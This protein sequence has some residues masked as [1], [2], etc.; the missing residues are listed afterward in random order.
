MS[1]ETYCKPSL[2]AESFQRLLAAAFILQSRLDWISRNPIR[3]ADAKRFAAL[4][5]A[6]KRT[7]SIRTSLM[8]WKGVEAVAIAII[9]CLM[10]GMSI[11]HL[12]GY[13]SST[14]SSGKLQ[15]R[16]AGRL[17]RSAPQVLLSSVLA[18]SQ[19]PATEKQAHDDGKGKVETYDGDLII[20]YQ[21]R[22]ANLPGLIRKGLTSSRALAQRSPR[23]NTPEA[24]VTEKVVRYGE[25]VTMWPSPR[26]G[27]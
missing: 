9:F 20:H 22:T 13:P 19:E 1:Q 3:T 23:K 10:M 12:L 6:R 16:D 24:M 7:P 15:T 11:H 5:I 26:H 2:D 25:D 14:S 8:F 18:L 4:A 27:H 17:T 21:P